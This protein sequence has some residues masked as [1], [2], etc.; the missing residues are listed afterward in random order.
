MSWAEFNLRLFAYNR[1]RNNERKDLREVAWSSFLASFHSD[2][3]R[4]PKTK[5]QFWPIGDE[6]VKK[7]VSEK[8]KAA[9]VK[10]MREYQ[11][12]LN[13]KA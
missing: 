10:A 12:K 2:P 1:V 7:G 6:Q 13:G 4:F 11:S 3:K 9:F 5:Q 8:H